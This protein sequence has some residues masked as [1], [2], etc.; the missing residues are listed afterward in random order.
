MISTVKSTNLPKVEVFVFQIKKG[1]HRADESFNGQPLAGLRSNEVLYSI[2]IRAFA[3][4]QDGNKT[5]SRRSP[6]QEPGGDPLHHIYCTVYWIPQNLVRSSTPVC[7]QREL[8]SNSDLIVHSPPLKSRA[9]TSRLG[10]R[11][12]ELQAEVVIRGTSDG[13]PA[14]FARV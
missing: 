7:C 9:W 11:R 10:D 4:N 13:T 12:L 6:M 3:S 5:G 1:S 8:D 14:R 2:S